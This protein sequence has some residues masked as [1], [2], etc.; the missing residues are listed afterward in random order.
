MNLNFIT[1]RMF[2]GTVAAIMATGAILNMAGS[3]KLGAGPQKL[4]KYIINGYGA[5]PA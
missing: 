2:V 4:A 1:S 5:G 3:G